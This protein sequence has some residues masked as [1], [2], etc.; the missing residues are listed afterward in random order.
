M[1]SRLKLPATASRV[2]PTAGGGLL[3]A[4][5]RGEDGALARALDL[6]GPLVWSIAR[7][8][9]PRHGDAEDAAQEAFLRLWRV[10]DR[11]DPS[12]GSEAAFV[13]AVT[14]NRVL[15]FR[16]ANQRRE[17]RVGAAEV[18][19]A[20]GAA[21]VGPVSEEARLAQRAMSELPEEQQE[22]LRL[23]VQRGLTQEDAA[24]SLG[25]PLGTVKTRVRSALM[26]LREALGA[27][28]GS[29][30]RGVTT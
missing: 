22:A 30:R 7:T 27:E 18:G 29:P 10:A 20:P 15:E 19:D 24:R 5:A 1:P 23:T 16:R 8:Y 12:R 13:V 21:E 25:L 9:C 11:Y 2:A 4:V 28:R 17:A 3:R 26:R 14:R 6:Y